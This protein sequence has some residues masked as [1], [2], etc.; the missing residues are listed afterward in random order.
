MGEEIKENVENET[1]AQFAKECVAKLNKEESAADVKEL[2]DLVSFLEDLMSKLE[3]LQQGIKWKEENP[4]N[5][6]GDLLQNAVAGG[7]PL[8][9]LINGLSSRFGI[10]EAEFAKMSAMDSEKDVNGNDANSN[11]KEEGVTTIGFGNDGKVEDDDGDVHELGSFG[12]TQTK[13]KKEEENVEKVSSRKRSC[14]EAGIGSD[15]ASNDVK[16]MKLNSGDAAV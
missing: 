5:G 2:E 15:D 7:D 12:T 1:L 3:E 13:K 6:K 9:A 14:N 10:D 8:Q 11:K 16:K 4:S